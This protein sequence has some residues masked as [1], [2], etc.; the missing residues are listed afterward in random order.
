MRSTRR[1]RDE[2][3][4]LETEHETASGSVTVIDFMPMLGANR[5]DL[6]RLVIGRKGRV[7]M[8]T[9]L[10]LRFDYGWTVPWVRAEGAGLV[11][12]AGPDTLHVTADIPLHGE[13]LHTVGAFEVGEGECVTF[14]RQ[15]TLDHLLAPLRRIER[16]EERIAIDR[17]M[18]SRQMHEVGR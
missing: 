18:H 9:E 1:Y 16:G 6:V 10:V 13:N 4:I 5:D 15:V 8:R 11:A 12:I 17:R 3:L 2:T 7:A 14:I